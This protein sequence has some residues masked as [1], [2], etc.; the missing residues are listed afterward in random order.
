[1]KK[2]LTDTLWAPLQK[3]WLDFYGMI[4]NIVVM[5]LI[6]LTGWIL[7]RIL[8][9][10]LYRLLRIIHFDRFAYRLGFA[11]VLS[12]A[13]VRSE[14]AMAVSIAAYYLLF[15]V[16]LLLGLQALEVPAIDMLISQLF[17]FLP[18]LAAAL[19]ILFAGYLL[20]AFVNRTVLIAAVNANFQF[21]R[22]L[23]TAAQS[24]VLI[25]FLAIALEQAGIGQNIIVATFSILFG[26]VVLALALAFG[27]GG[28]DLAHDILERRFGKAK[29]KA[30]A[31][32]EKDEFSHL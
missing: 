31:K 9:W 16:F 3:L 12:R 17:A 30:K 22:A 4:D 27:L 21:A 13:G 32:A 23:A 29:Q 18:R 10:V 19:L 7:G 2:F 14:P 1:M 24:L 28:R 26:G 8:R 11:E 6:L 20:S 25:F 15:F 5:L